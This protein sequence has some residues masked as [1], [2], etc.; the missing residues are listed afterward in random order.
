MFAIILGM[1]CR[2]KVQR[3]LVNQFRSLEEAEDF[4]RIDYF[5]GQQEE[6]SAAA[7][8]ATSTPLNPPPHPPTAQ[9]VRKS[10]TH[11]SPS[12]SVEN[13]TLQISTGDLIR[14]MMNGFL[15][16]STTWCQ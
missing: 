8:K 14:L 1:A 4:Y 3:H 15:A 9:S 12:S 11:I 7:A 2:R 5:E 16:R 6:S 10:I 13:F